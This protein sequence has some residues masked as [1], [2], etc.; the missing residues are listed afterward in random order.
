MTQNYEHTNEQ[1]SPNP[2]AEKWSSIGDK[3]E[4]RCITGEEAEELA[5][6]LAT[7]ELGSQL[8]DVWRE[9]RKQEDGSYEPRIK[10]T[11][12][13]EW[14][15]K[16]GTNEVDIANTAFGDLPRD[17]Q[18]ENEAAARVVIREFHERVVPYHAKDNDGNPNEFV[19]D[20]ARVVHDEWLKRNAW[21]AGDE[22]LDKP[23]D[24]LDDEEKAKDINQVML[25]LKLAWDDGD[26]SL[27]KID[28]GYGK[29]SEVYRNYNKFGLEQRY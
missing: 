21:A 22:K 28:D 8:H 25:A 15:A 9:S 23:F 1:G 29:E 17:Y 18:L 13:P 14:I 2:D 19:L 20:V 5:I 3:N 4:R 16:H 26:F 24:E 11:T 7:Q 12:D 27:K 10:K 6:E